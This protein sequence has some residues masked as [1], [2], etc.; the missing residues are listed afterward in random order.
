MN[1]TKKQEMDPTPSKKKILLCKNCILHNKMNPLRPFSHVYICKECIK[2]NNIESC[3]CC[4]TN[5]TSKRID[6]DS[7]S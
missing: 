3:D 2:F 5:L 6:L 1:K 4:S 7:F